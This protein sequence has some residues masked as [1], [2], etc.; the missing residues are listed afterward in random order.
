MIGPELSSSKTAGLRRMRQVPAL[1]AAALLTVLA[2]LSAPPLR[3]DIRTTK[4]NLAERFGLDRSTV[5]EREVCVFCHF[6]AIVDPLGGVLARTAAT[7]PPRWQQ[8][9]ATD[10]SYP[11]YDDIGRVGLD[12]S[13]PVGSQSMACLACHDSNQAFV[14]AGS[15]MDHPF[16]VPYRGVRASQVQ[17]DAALE[18]VRRAGTPLREGTYRLDQ[19][20]ADYRP[21]YESVVENRRIYWVSAVGNSLRRAKTDLPLYSRANL[22]VSEDIPFIECTSCHDPH[23]SNALFLRV[24][25]QQNQLC[26]TCHAK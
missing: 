26:L 13:A 3:A 12:G 16:G 2:M 15:A 18:I 8:S 7:S 11:I 24:G 23:T 20:S 21:A 14:V 1:L 19:T 4:H 22:G 17:I 6:P 9:V 5:D 10:Y 25:N